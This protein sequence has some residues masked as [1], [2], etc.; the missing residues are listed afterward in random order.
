[1]ENI[2][3]SV[4]VPLVLH[5]GT[6]IDEKSLCDAIEIGAAKVNYGTIL[7]QRY[8]EALRNSLDT[9]DENPHHLLGYGGDADIMGGWRSETRLW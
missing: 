9:S 1:L 5:G 8:L 7:K 4:P 2:A 6:G 3:E